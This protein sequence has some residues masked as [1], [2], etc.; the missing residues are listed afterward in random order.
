MSIVKVV[1]ASENLNTPYQSYDNLRTWICVGRRN[2]FFHE[3]YLSE[4]DCDVFI[5][6]KQ[7]YRWKDKESVSNLL[8]VYKTESN[9]AAC[10]LQCDDKTIGGVAIFKSSGATI[11]NLQET[12]SCPDMRTETLAGLLVKEG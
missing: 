11:E 6:I 8:D 9:M 3:K 2:T 10:N 1:V 12:F 4:P 5:C 7:G